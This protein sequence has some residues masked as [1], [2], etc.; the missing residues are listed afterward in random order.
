MT[1]NHVSPYFA[2]SDQPGHAQNTQTILRGR[3]VPLKL[4]FP[5]T[6]LINCGERAGQ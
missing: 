2:L 3:T 6:P 1:I 4:N 5:S